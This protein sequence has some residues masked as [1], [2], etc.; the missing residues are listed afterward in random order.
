[1]NSNDY[2]KKLSNWISRYRL[3][4]TI[5]TIKET[6]RYDFLYQA[7]IN[8]KFHETASIDE[9]YRFRSEIMLIT[10]LFQGFAKE[11]KEN[12]FLFLDEFEDAKVSFDEV[13]E[14]RNFECTVA[15]Q[16]PHGLLSILPGTMLQVNELKYANSGNMVCATYTHLLTDTRNKELVEYFRGGAE[17]LLTLK[18]LES[19]FKPI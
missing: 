13:S 1:M 15:F 19:N 17:T 3:A 9:L 8:P 14:T 7:L 18:I 2:R 12:E 4:H 6:N 5:E 11:V 10:S 16:D